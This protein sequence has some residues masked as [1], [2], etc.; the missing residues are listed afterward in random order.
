[1]YYL[2]GIISELQNFICSE[3]IQGQC[4]MKNDKKII[5]ENMCNHNLGKAIPVLGRGGP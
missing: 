4:G 2:K 3:Q 5:L 1:M